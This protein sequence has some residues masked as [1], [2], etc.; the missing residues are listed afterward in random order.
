LPDYNPHL[1]DFKLSRLRGMPIGCRRIHSLLK[2]TGDFCRFDRAADYPHPLLHLE[3]WG[4]DA[5]PKAEKV[6]NLAAAIQNLQL[7]MAQVQRFLK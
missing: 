4:N 2:Y 3:A 5:G 1:V 6:E 7:A